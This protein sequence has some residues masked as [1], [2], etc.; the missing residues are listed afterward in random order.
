MESNYSFCC[1]NNR[2]DYGSHGC[3]YMLL[4]NNKINETFWI[5]DFVIVNDIGK[6]NGVEEKFHEIF[7]IQDNSDPAMPRTVGKKIFSGSGF[8]SYFP[9]ITDHIKNM[10]I[11]K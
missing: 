5:D 6:I 8:L 11:L 1:P 10:D 7:Y 9:G 3:Y 2:R 4:V